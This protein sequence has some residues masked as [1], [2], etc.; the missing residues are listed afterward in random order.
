MGV[1]VEHTKKGDGKTFSKK[2]QTLEIHYTGTLIDGKKFDSS[3]DR[4]K[5]FI[6]KIGV[7]HVIKGWEVGI[8][9]ISVG[10]KAILTINPEYGYGASGL[11]GTIPPNATM[12]FDVELIAIK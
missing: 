8:P 9:Q 10:G 11:P 3:R 1:D 12:I 4:G 5:P 2:G 7:G 6:T